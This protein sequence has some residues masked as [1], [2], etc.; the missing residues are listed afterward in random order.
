MR[1]GERESPIRPC[2]LCNSRYPEW[3]GDES[4]GMTPREV[5]ELVSAQRGNRDEVTKARLRQLTRN[6][7]P[8]ST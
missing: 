7:I 3:E 6:P 4:S 1:I 2:P 8:D 5:D